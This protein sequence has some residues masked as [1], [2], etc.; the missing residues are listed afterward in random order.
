VFDNIIRDRIKVIERYVV[1]GDVLDLGCVDARPGREA[2]SVRIHRKA[3]ALFRRILELNP[4]AVG[5]DIDPAGV[6]VLTQM[7]FNVVC[8]D[9]EKM[10]LGRQFDAIIAGEI[11]EHLESPGLFLRNMHRHLKPG[12][13]ILIS[14]PN[15][16]HN[17]QTWKI[18]RHGRPTVHEGHMGWQDP[19]TLKQLLER[20][21]YELVEGYWVQPRN[22]AFKTWKKMFRTYFSHSFLVVARAAVDGQQRAA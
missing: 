20:T 12:G 16:F 19:L 2:A 15:P 10:E 11:I 7:G 22:K 21:G 14:T 9:V 13:H 17:A 4:R 6:R 5:V 8:A 18:W 1:E 3:D